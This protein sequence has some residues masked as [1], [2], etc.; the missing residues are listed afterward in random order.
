V[1]GHGIQRGVG[2]AGDPIS[3]DGVYDL[4]TKGVMAFPFVGSDCCD[5]AP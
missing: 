2:A 3:I 5:G 1:G 4:R